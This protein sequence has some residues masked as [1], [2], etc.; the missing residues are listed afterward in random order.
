MY[1]DYKN[2]SFGKKA[3]EIKASSYFT[4]VELEIL[5]YEYKEYEYIFSGKKVTE[6]Q[7]EKK[8][9]WHGREFLLKSMQKFVVQSY[10]KCSLFIFFSFNITDEKMVGCYCKYFCIHSGTIPGAQQ[11]L[12]SSRK[13]NTKIVMVMHILLLFYKIYNVFLNIV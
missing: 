2:V 8:E 1:D 5:M 6:Q 11:T 7:H 9:N 13:S 10:I 4:L 12:G 3:T